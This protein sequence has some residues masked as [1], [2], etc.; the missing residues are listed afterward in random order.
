MANPTAGDP[1][2]RAA[3][4]TGR[5]QGVSFRYATLREA[6][7]LGVTGWVRNT[8]AGS[9]E[10][11]V[12]GDARRRRRVAA[13]GRDGPR[14]R[15][16]RPRGRGAATPR[17]SERSTSECSAD[18]RRR[19]RAPPGA[20]E[21]P[22]GPP[23]GAHLVTLGRR[24]VPSSLDG[25]SRARSDRGLVRYDAARHRRAPMSVGCWRSSPC[26]PTRWSPRTAWSRSSG[27]SRPRTER[28]D[29]C[30]RTSRTSD[31][32]WARSGWFGGATA[33]SWRSKPESSTPNGSPKHSPK[34]GVSWR[35]IPSR[36]R[37]GSTTRSNCGGD[38]PSRISVT[39]CR[40]S[41]SRPSG[42]SSSG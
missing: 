12:Q 37:T 20:L 41:A 2:R 29:P 40:P 39:T 21:H 26:P 28:F 14:G 17:R 27:A 22:A 6:T 38:I 7:R 24:S 33:T 32:P 30:T 31:A 42:W 3:T 18:R 19:L 10:L 35:L 1:I 23:T 5:V 25:R 4:V 34:H 36:R 16:G 8:A 9:V 15:P 13:M 11:E